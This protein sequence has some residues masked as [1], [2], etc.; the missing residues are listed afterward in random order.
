[1]APDF[2]SQLGQVGPLIIG[3]VGICVA[4]INQ[5]RQL[6]AQMFIEFSGRFQQILRV[7][8]TEAFGSPRTAG[9]G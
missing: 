1:M 5:R 3:S 6:N 9:F 2:L 8:P 4:L 7:F